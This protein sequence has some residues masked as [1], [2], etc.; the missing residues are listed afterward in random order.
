MESDG[1]YDGAVRTTT[2]PNA[3]AGISHPDEPARG[4]RR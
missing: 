1:K 3:L 4:R 2:R